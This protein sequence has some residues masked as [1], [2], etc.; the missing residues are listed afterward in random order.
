MI[1]KQ[2][3]KSILRGTKTNSKIYNIHNTFLLD[4]VVSNPGLRV[5]IASSEV[6][7]SQELSPDFFTPVLHWT[8][9]LLVAN[10]ALKLLFNED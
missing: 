9:T 7:M 2:R 4:D 1:C 10:N 3:R 5:V 6:F 8:S